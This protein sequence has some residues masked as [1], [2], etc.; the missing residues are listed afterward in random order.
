[1][2]FQIQVDIPV[3]IHTNANKEHEKS[4]NI[5]LYILTLKYG[6]FANVQILSKNQYDPLTDA[7][8]SAAVAVDLADKPLEKSFIL[9]KNHSCTPNK[10]KTW[11][12]VTAHHLP[13]DSFYVK[14][15]QNRAKEKKNNCLESLDKDFSKRSVMTMTFLPRK[16]VSRSLH[17]LNLW[18][19]FWQS[20]YKIVQ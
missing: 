14:S 9:L 11:L 7:A 8:V 1:M 10:N 12:K 2:S 18:T 16:L 3:K 19:V 6:H 20:L 13:T 15:E 17:I 4:Y 5:K